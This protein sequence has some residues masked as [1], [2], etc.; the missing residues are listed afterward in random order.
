[1]TISADF[2]G[3]LAELPCI[4]PSSL[5][6]PALKQQR[7]E[8]KFIQ[9]LRADDGDSTYVPTNGVYSGVDDVVQ[10][11]NGP[12][13]SAILHDARN[14]G[15]TN[16]QI[17]LA[18]PGEPAGGFYLHETTLVNPIAYALFV[19]ALTHDGSGDLSR[20]DLNTLATS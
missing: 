5:C 1:M 8:T 4:V 6:T 11:E 10:P 15:V 17:Q 2:H 19:D 16:A 14:V 3:T 20:I 18:C 7:Y 12:N 13:V 9:T